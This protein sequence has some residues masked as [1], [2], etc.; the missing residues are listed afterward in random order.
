MRSSVPKPHSA[1]AFKPLLLIFLLTF[2]AYGNTFDAGWHLDDYQ[3]IVNNPKIRIEALTPA[4]LMQAMQHPADISIWRPVA[5]LSF[6]LNWLVGEYHIFGYHLLNILL[7]CLTAGLLYLVILALYRTPALKEQNGQSAPFIALLATVLWALNPIQTQAVT[8]VV[9]RMAVMATLF[10][11]L[12]VYFYV[13]GR[14]ET[15]FSGRIFHLALCA[16]SLLCAFCSKENAATLLIALMVLE[17][18]FFRDLAQPGVKKIFGVSVF[19]GVLLVVGIGLVFFDNPFGFLTGYPYRTFTPY[20]RLLT[21]ARVMVLY[22]SQIFYPVPTRLSV[23]HD[24]PVSVSLLSPWTTLPAI[25]LVVGLVALGVYWMGR[26]PWLSFA[27]LFFFINHLIESSVIGL[28]LVFEHRNYLP[29]LFLFVP[30]AQ[31][32]KQLIDRYRLTRPLMGHVLVAGIVLLVIGLGTGTYIR[33]LAW[34]SE[35]TLWEDTLAKAPRSIRA[36]HELAYQ[37]YEKSGQYD[38]ALALYQRGLGLGGQSVYETALSLNNIASIHFTRGEYGKA[39]TYWKKCIESWPQYTSAYYRLGLTQTR[40][41]KWAQ[42]A[43]TLSEIPRGHVADV[44]SLRLQGVILLNVH[45]PDAAVDIFKKILASHP[46]DGQSLMYLGLSYDLS[47]QYD[48]GYREFI[49]AAAVRPGDPMPQLL[50]ANNRN[51]AGA[52]K[53]TGHHLDRFITSVGPSQAEAYVQEAA[54]RFAQLNISFDGL[55]TML[56]EKMDRIA[57]DSR[58]SAKRLDGVQHGLA[59]GSGSDSTRPHLPR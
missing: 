52:E 7:H 2:L 8:Y 27:I 43:E 50:L 57:E 19:V 17:F 9:Q 40:L 56:S 44:N 1:P 41:G 38:A 47:G 32:I 5:Y 14:L 23:Y 11:L 55:R 59:V 4:S 15:S 33:N 24:F 37:V 45:K 25:L 36:H 39:E 42:A 34:A 10:G 18:I 28:E 46:Q 12:A 48:E 51:M 49:S 6:A 3:S 26:R 20:E 31:A 58:A 53:A 29:S 30:A 35:R 22:L 54:R 13:A 21:E 16:A